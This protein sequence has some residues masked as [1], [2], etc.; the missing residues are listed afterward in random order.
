MQRA[1]AARAVAALDVDHHLIA[2]QMCG[3]GPVIAIGP[4]FTTTLRVF[5]RVRRVLRGLVLG[6]SLLEVLK[7]ELELLHSELFATATELMARQALDQQ[8]QLVVLGVQFRVLLCRRGDDL[9]QHLL[10][11]ADVV[12]QAVEVDLHATM[13]NNAF[14]SVPVLRLGLRDFY[15]ANSGLRA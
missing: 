7:P 5:R 4:S 12:G 3:Q 9:A 14:A 8:S 1:A 11:E 13:M 10:Q 2:G 15:P 6:D